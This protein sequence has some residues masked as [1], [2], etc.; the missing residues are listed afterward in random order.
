[1]ES[2]EIKAQKLM[3][4][5]YNKTKHLP[6][7]KV[8]PCTATEETE[9]ENKIK[10]LKL[11]IYHLEKDIEKWKKAVSINS[12]QI[13]LQ[14]GDSYYPK[15]EYLDFLKIKESAIEG[16]KQ[17]LKK[18]MEELQSYGENPYKHEELERPSTLREAWLNSK[19]LN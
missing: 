6:I 11:S 19:Y 7:D 4:E 17:E 5:L 1:M 10:N 13:N 18:K 14:G 9:K 2:K 8:F 3:E 12:M 15:Y 16:A